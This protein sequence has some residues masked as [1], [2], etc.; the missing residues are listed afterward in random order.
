MLYVS[1]RALNK[2]TILANFDANQGIERINMTKKNFN[3]YAQ[4]Q[5]NQRRTV[6]LNFMLPVVLLLVFL[7]LYCFMVW[8]NMD[9]GM[10]FWQS[11]T[12]TMSPNLMKWFAI[13]FA[14]W[15]II[16]LL[17]SASVLHN[18]VSTVMKASHA[19]QVTDEMKSADSQVRMYDD[20]V[21][22]LAIAYGMPKPATY[23]VEDT[24]E[25]NA[26]A[27]GK[28]DQA[29]VAI[30]RPLLDMLNRQQVSGVMGHELAHVAAGDSQTTMRFELFV[31]GLS[32]V[33]LVGWTC[34]KFGFFYVWPSDDDDSGWIGKAIVGAI[35]VLGL[36]VAIA[37]LVGKLCATLLKFAMSRTREFDADAMSAKVNQDPQGL[38]QALTK[39][40]S[41]VG[42]QTGQKSEPLP[43]Q[44]SNL[45][46]VDNKTHLLDD[47]P[48]TKARIERLQE[49]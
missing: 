5:A 47:H 17:W 28:P 14:I 13:I 3:F 43:T 9:D 18:P 39:I 6:L 15:W 30:T 22:E 8:G 12:R 7:V 37:G 26:F 4:H 20:V 25:P 24:S 36:V 19:S 45:Y 49:V 44:F 23:I 2:R 31:T 29:G 21:E 41:W 42:E 46:L 33:M 34:A 1:Y 11:F 10:T 16:I 35:G 40:D 32:F 48:S 27:T 38:I